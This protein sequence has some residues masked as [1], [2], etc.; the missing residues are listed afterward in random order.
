M[1]TFLYYALMLLVGY[2]WYRYGQKL[3]NQGLRDE[4]DELTKPPV[5]PIGFPLVAAVAC[6]LLFAA[7]RALVLREIPCVGKGC[8]GQIYTLA[9]HA[10]PYWA[11]LFFLVWL[12]LALGYAMYVTVRIWTRP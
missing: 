4:N 6:Y 12:V 2:V 5:G 1:L 7:L 11:N 3:L 8:A 10:G 9:E